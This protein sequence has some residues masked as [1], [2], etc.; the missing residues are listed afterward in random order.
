LYYV[1]DSEPKGAEI[2]LALEDRLL[3]KFGV[4]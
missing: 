2:L 3:R 4:W 1:Y